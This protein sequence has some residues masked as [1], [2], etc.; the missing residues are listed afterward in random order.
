MK[1]IN[2]LINLDEPGWPLVQEWISEATNL[3]EVLPNDAAQAEA[4]LYQTQVTTRSPMGAIIHSTGGILVDNGW[5]RILGSGS[6]KLNRSLPAW[7]LGKSFEQPGDA[8]SFLLVADDAI[9]GFWAINGGEFGEDTGNLYYLAPDTLEWEE[10]E[11]SYSEFLTFCFNGDLDEFYEGF[12][13]KGWEKDVSGLDG[14]EVFSFY[15]FLWTNEGKNIDKLERK[16]VPVQEAYQLA[17][18]QRDT[19]EEE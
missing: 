4:A 12:R 1:E 17:Q 5:L 9:G 18:E 16:K 2:E 8:P 6:A 13:W 19:F 15:P 7:N 11:L 3:V 14:N 10:T